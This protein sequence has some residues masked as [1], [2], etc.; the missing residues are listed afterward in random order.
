MTFAPLIHLGCSGEL[1]FFLCS[2]YAPMCEQSLV[3]LSQKV[4]GPCRPLCERVRDKCEHVLVGFGYSWPSVLDCAKF[5]SSNRHEH[6]CMEGPGEEHR[7]PGLPHSLFNNLQTNP[8]FMKKVKEQLSAANSGAAD[9]PGRLKNYMEL[10]DNTDTESLRRPVGAV[11]AG[12][13]VCTVNKEL[14]LLPIFRQFKFIE[15]HQ[16]H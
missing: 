15:S 9:V 1:Q 10:L 16:T 13:T 8:L 5:P 7:P 12:K 14:G 4:I 3:E 6:M 2:V 11:S